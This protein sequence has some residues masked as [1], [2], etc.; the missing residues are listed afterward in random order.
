MIDLGNIQLTL[1]LNILWI[2]LLL[3][4]IAACL[5]VIFMLLKRDK[6]RSF[7]LISLSE[8]E[9]SILK[10]NYAH[11]LDKEFD[12]KNRDLE[13]QFKERIIKISSLNLKLKNITSSLNKDDILRSLSDLLHNS[14]GVGKGYIFL[15]S[16][17]SDEIIP[18]S[19]I[20]EKENILSLESVKLDEASFIGY[21]STFGYPINYKIAIKDPQLKNLVGRGRYPCIMAV[22]LKYKEKVLGVICVSETIMELTDDEFSILV[23]VAQVAGMVINNASIYALTK[24]ELR[25]TK[26]ITQKEIESKLKLKQIFERYTSPQI[27]DKILKNPSI[28][29]MGGS[30]RKSTVMFIDIRG[31][32]SFCESFNPEMVVKVLNIYLERLTDII[33]SNNGTVDK[34]IGDEIMACWGVPVFDKEHSSNAIKTAIEIIYEVEKIKTEHREKGLPELDVGVGINCGEA[35]FGNIGSSKRM[36]M[37]L[38]G[39][40][41]NIAARMESLTRQF[42]CHIIV[43][44]TFYKKIFSQVQAKKHTNIPVKG[45]KE[46][47]TI[48]EILGEKERELP[49]LKGV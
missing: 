20:G 13:F 7:G 36:D 21:C 42:K 12:R 17:Y 45:K 46:T 27:V 24:E 34:F 3:L 16:E 8:N 49:K 15:L 32:T 2:C 35:I 30:K 14:L 44:E 41:V 43:S 23:S 11:F 40:T 47:M 26:K 28:I 9:K 22:P 1:P 37:T 48:Y 5:V 4:G 33:F 19:T 29:E 38:V 18:V 39:D 25:S 10:T 6:D 31:F